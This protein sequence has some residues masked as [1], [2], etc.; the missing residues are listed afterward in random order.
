MKTMAK[1]GLERAADLAHL[2]KAIMDIIKA[3]MSGGWAGAAIA[4]L[5]HYWPKLVPLIAAGLLMPVVIFSCLPAVLFGFGPGPERDKGERHAALYGRYEEYRDA[6]IHTLIVEQGVPCKVEYINEPFDKDWLTAIDCVNNGNDTDRLS[7]DGLKDLIRKT[8]TCEMKDV[9]PAELPNPP[10]PW[11][12]T[13]HRPPDELPERPVTAYKIIRV[14]TLSPEEVMRG[15]GF[16]AEEFNW[17]RLI[18]RSQTED[19]GDG[20]DEVREGEAA[21]E[22]ALPQAAP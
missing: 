4:A 6:Q 9:I 19:E 12:D 7:E 15:I 13:S 5:K 18:H 21:Q 1:G 22:E 17:A 10:S 3:A 11:E 16:D 20:G 14:T 8:Y 2:A